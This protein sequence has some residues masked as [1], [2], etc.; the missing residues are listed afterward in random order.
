MSNRFSVLVV[1]V[2]CCLQLGCIGRHSFLTIQMCLESEQGVADFKAVMEDLSGHNGM[3]FIDGS[4]KAQKNSIEMN[5]A[6][7][8][9]I[10][11]FGAKSRDN[12]GFQAGNTGLSAF[13]VAIGFGEGSNPQA[14][15][16]FAARV[17]DALQQRWEVH[18]V[19]PGQ[20]AFPRGDCPSKQLE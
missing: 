6:P 1:I 5:V 16:Q 13:E 11:F 10:I 12:Y 3:K 20:G 19:P 14:A 8:Y 2:I 4:E 7:N 17:I 15:R 18:T 9:P